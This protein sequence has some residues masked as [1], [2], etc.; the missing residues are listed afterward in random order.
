MQTENSG[1]ARP[2]RRATAIVSVAATLV[3][4]GM[5]IALVQAASCVH[6]PPVQDP[7]SPSPSPSSEPS[8]SSIPVT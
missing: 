2:R 6:D 4:V 5:G 7:S 8:P 3:L 1:P